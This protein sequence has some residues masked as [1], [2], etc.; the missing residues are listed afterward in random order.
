[1]GIRQIHTIVRQQ[2]FKLSYAMHMQSKMSLYFD[3][4]VIG[5]VL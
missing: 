1:M 2:H 3:G 5:F 4:K